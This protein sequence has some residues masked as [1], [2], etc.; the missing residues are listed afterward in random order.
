MLPSALGISIRILSP[1]HADGGGD[2]GAGN[3]IGKKAA[4]TGS[5]SCCRAAR[6]HLW[7]R[8]ALRPC[9]RAIRA[10]EAP[11]CWQSATIRALNSA[12]KRRRVFGMS[13]V[14]NR[15]ITGVHLKIGGHYH[16]W[17]TGSSRWVRR[18]VTKYHSEG[19]VIRSSPTSGMTPS[20]SSSG[21]RR[22]VSR[23]LLRVTTPQSCVMKLM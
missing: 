16:Q 13:D 5:V 8:L 21:C 19:V 20:R 10:T 18:T 9:S 23:R 7:T 1:V 14:L 2:E 11:D 17:M 4:G 6:I 15:V 3:G 12:V 22:S